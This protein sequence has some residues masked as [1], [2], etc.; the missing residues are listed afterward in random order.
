MS[1]TNIP[2][3]TL[4]NKVFLPGSSMTLAMKD[5]NLCK[6]HLVS[7]GKKLKMF[8]IVTFRDPGKKIFYSYG[9][10]V[11]VASESP[12]INSEG[13][14]PGLSMGL[15]NQNS[16]K[17]F[18]IG[19]ERFKILNFSEENGTVYA[20]IQVE[21][22]RDAKVSE[23]LLDE[24]KNI[25]K[26]YIRSLP[27]PEYITNEREK[28]ISDEQDVSQLGF[29]IAGLLE[30]P[31]SDKQAILEN[32]RLEDR[33]QKLIQLLSSFLA[34]DQLSQEVSEKM[35]QGLSKRL[36]IRKKEIESKLESTDDHQVLEEKL[37]SLEIPVEYKKVVFEEMK[38]LKSTRKTSVEYNSLR[39]YL[40]TV[41][42]LPWNVSSKDSYDI[43]KAREK[44]DSDHFGLEKVKKR[45][46]E[47]IAVRALRGDMN[48]S[49]ICFV[50]PP[51][52]GKTSLGKSV[53]DAI[54]RKFVRMALGGVRDEAE[55]RGHRRT[56]VA[57]MPGS[58][59]NVR[60]I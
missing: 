24:L 17:L 45:I 29:I 36:E 44:L 7:R 13:M 8:G 23:K 1:K 19:V 15:T 58:F 33:T 39:N 38:R 49:I 25:G 40:D 59:I 4:T 3:V 5:Y 52:V 43:H 16:W 51:G 60:F 42:A 6:N 57:S 47:Y 53:A 34:E 41:V 22:D 26:A 2:L 10:L 50:G 21:K 55:I 11:G 46:L 35:K 20:N 28:I 37:Q 9:T 27:T 30:I 54:G 32:F 48:G 56:Y 18:V 14:F 12:I 31:F